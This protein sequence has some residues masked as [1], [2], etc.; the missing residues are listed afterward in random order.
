MGISE[1]LENS[2]QEHRIPPRLFVMLF[3]LLV[4]LVAFFLFI[5][6][7]IFNVGSVIVQGNKY[8]S[9]EEIYRIAGIPETINIFRLNTSE[10]KNRLMRDLRIS[11]VNVSRQFPSAILL[12][13]KERQPLAY[14]ANSYGFVQ[15]DKD[16]VVLAVLKNLKEV[17]VP[18]I[19]GI[20]L[21]NVYVGDKV[22]M[23]PIK[24]VLSYLDAL[25]ETALNRLS[26]FNI[27]T[28]GQFVVYTVDS[29][30]IRL[31]G[32]DRLLE[33]AQLTTDILNDVNTKK[34]QVEYID[35]S[36]GSPFI[37]FKK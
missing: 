1:R 7:S 30:Q 13:V 31:G 15:L 23:P 33:K 32:N 9:T 37:K 20:R 18:I 3:F 22:E 35:L 5:N 2:R 29:V 16:G 14:A 28:S 10:I 17:N 4:I 34:M 6:A 11:E 8:V 21:G 26:E 27:K 19:T 24:D 12:D 36:Y 25:D